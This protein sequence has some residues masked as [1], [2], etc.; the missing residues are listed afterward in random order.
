M[1]NY[2]IL[3]STHNYFTNKEA[4]FLFELRELMKEKQPYKGLKI[5]HNI[6]ITLESIIKIECLLLAGADVTVTGLKTLPPMQRALEILNDANVKI[7]LQR[8]NLKDSFDIHLDCCAEL[9]ELNAPHFGAVELTQTGT[10]IYQ[11]INLSYPVISV[12]DCQLK[13]LETIGT[14]D[15]FVRAVQS[16]TNIQLTT[17][18]IILFGYGKVG[19]GIINALKPYTDDIVIVEK[20]EKVEELIKN[21]VSKNKI[22]SFSNIQSIKQELKN[23]FCAVTA[24]GIVNLISEHFT[25]EDFAGVYLANMGAGDEFGPKFSSHDVLFEKLPI[26]FSLQFPTKMQYLDPIFYAHNTSIDLLI[27]NKISLGYMAF[28]ADLSID[29]LRK[30]GKFHAQDITEIMKNF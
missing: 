7:N 12:D 1:I 14:G 4:P 27:A 3:A 15:A 17:K 24:T 21:D 10:H 6:P 26:N 25:K 30:W 5:L 22:I 16:L 8:D 2:K 29:I 13:C 28:P 23:T 9:T 11:K 20:D 19:K 18:K